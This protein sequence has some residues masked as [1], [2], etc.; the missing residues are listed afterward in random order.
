MQPDQAH[1]M[2]GSNAMCAVTAILETGMKPMQTPTT[3]IILDTAA[4]LVSATAHCNGKK[5][6]RV[7]LDMPPAFVAKPQSI[8]DTP[9]WG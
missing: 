2:S 7:S 8:I 1:A 4:G 9:K 5:V 3:R 6:K